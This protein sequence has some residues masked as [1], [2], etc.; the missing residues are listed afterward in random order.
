MS[1]SGRDNAFPDIPRVSF[2]ELMA[3]NLA[4]LALRL[5]C[6]GPALTRA[7]H[8][9]LLDVKAC[10]ALR[11]G[12]LCDCGD[13]K[14]ICLLSSDVEVRPYPRQEIDGVLG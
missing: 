12:S 13:H 3:T 4:V 9:V 1:A 5:H 2:I 10:D 6:A 7:M 8:R 14:R 11:W